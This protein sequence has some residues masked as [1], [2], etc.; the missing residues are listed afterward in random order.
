MLIDNSLCGLIGESPYEEPEIE[1]DPFDC[2]ER[3]VEA[4]I[5]ESQGGSCERLA[6]Y[7]NHLRQVLD[8][9]A[10]AVPQKA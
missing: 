3:Y 8:Q 1:V 6:V 10:E 4:K 5:E 9:L 7:E 2:I